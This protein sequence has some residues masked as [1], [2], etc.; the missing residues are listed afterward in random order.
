MRLGFARFIGLTAEEPF[1]ISFLVGLIIGA[2]G[3]ALWPFFFRWQHDFRGRPFV[4][5]VILRR[6]AAPNFCPVM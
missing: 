3:V 6:Y 2:T 5:T 1:R 4:L